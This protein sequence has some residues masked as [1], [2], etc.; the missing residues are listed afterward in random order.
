MFY[1]CKIKTCFIMLKESYTLNDVM[2]KF[3]L[4][5]RISM[6]IL[7]SQIKQIDILKWNFLII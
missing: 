7:L 3:E 2:S 1:K 6:H 4:H 5:C